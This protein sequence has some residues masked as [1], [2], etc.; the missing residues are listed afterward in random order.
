[1]I[2]DQWVRADNYFHFSKHKFTCPLIDL[3]DTRT[4]QGDFSSARCLALPSKHATLVQEIPIHTYIHTYTYLLKHE[5]VDPLLRGERER[6]RGGCMKQHSY[7]ASKRL[8]YK[9]SMNINLTKFMSINL[10]IN[11][12]N[13]STNISFVNET[14]TYNFFL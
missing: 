4:L 12:R 7:C 1:M 13:F 3:Y 9:N 14:R 6:Q 2:N 5:P 10:V 11:R 8:T